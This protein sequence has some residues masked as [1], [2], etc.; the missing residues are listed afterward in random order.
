M[1]SL[2]KFFSLFFVVLAISCGA[3]RQ[4][5]VPE[6]ALNP[7]LI[8][9]P[10]TAGAEKG[11]AV[12]VISFDK[13]EHDFGSVVDGEKVSFSFHFTNTGTGDLLIRHAQATCGCTVPEW[14]KDPIAPGKDGFIT[15][16]FDSK[17]RL[18]MIHK[19]VTVIA[20]TIPNTT[21]VTITG[22]VKSK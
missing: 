5:D 19:T 2:Q 15:V 7:D 11:K 3:P 4:E 17:G 8:D 14:P 20:N 10:S 16:T 1:M 18:G 22:E 21:T 9:N 12:P 13:T 6:N